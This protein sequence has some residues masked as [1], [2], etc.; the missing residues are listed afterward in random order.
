M[1][2]E[3]EDAEKRLSKEIEDLQQRIRALESDNEQVLSSVI[4]C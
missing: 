2:Q 3:R 1:Q 4:L